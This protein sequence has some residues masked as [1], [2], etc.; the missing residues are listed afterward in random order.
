MKISIKMIEILVVIN[1][2]RNNFIEIDRFIGVDLG[3][4]SRVIIIYLISI[5]WVS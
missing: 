3:V 1:V 5:Y 2:V 4:L